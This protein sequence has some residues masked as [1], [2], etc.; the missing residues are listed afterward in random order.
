MKIQAFAL[1]I[2][3]VAT[4]IVFQNCAKGGFQADLASN[5]SVSLP[6]ITNTLAN[7]GSLI[8]SKSAGVFDSNCLNNSSFDACIFWKNPVAERGVAYSGILEFE[9]NIDADQKFGVKLTNLK[10]PSTLT[11]NALN[12]Y[13][14]GADLNQEIH[15]ALTGGQ[16][17]QSYLSDGA[18][19]AATTRS[20]ST[21]QLMAYFWLNH[22]QT[23]L[24]KRTGTSFSENFLTYVDAF[25]TDP[26]LDSSLRD[27][28][29]FTYG[30]VP[31]DRFI[32]MG[33]SSK[34]KNNQVIQSHEMALSAEVY[35][36]EMGHANL[37]AAKGNDPAAVSTDSNGR[38]HYFIKTCPG[39]PTY[40]SDFKKNVGVVTSTTLTDL[41]RICEVGGGKLV[42]S[43]FGVC[44]T[45]Q[46]CFDAIN[47][48]QA[49]FHYMMMFPEA[50]ALGETIFNDVNGGYDTS[51]KR[52]RQLV[53]GT[54]YQCTNEVAAVGIKRNAALDLSLSVEQFFQGSSFQL[55]NCSTEIPGEV[56]GMGTAYASILW[57]IYIN[58]AINQ[59]QFE[60]AFQAHLQ[61]LGSSTTFPD[62]WMALRADYLAVGGDRSGQT[63]ID[64]V[65]GKK[66]VIKPASF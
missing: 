34:S 35:L 52:G 59:R 38:T 44:Q 25:A 33:Y 51:P 55:N 23:E 31:S 58:S 47:E 56:H 19:A 9:T 11:S 29:F 37:Y 62:A 42:Y 15:L 20:K 14:S 63:V 54:T 2:L 43:T 41:R 40:A 39:D 64:N 28:A 16:F 65:F 26:A 49:D 6:P 3:S 17:R 10:A 45:N 53:S 46:G 36:H 60:K 7:S 5:L 22:M 27:N 50:T 24:K 32:V 66:G 21:A 57:E 13:Y 4:V 48:G 12:V 8:S 30:T 18:A 61:K 1:L